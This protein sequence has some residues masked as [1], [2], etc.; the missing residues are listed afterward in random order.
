[1]VGYAE[2]NKIYNTVTY[3]ASLLSSL[4]KYSSRKFWYSLNSNQASII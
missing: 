4:G 3:G 1:M 2:R